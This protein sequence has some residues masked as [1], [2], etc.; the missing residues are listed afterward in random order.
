MPSYAPRTDPFSGAGD[1]NIF[2]APAV[3]HANN[4]TN[5]LHHPPTPTSAHALNLHSCWAEA[6]I[7]IARMTLTIKLDG[8]WSSFQLANN[9]PPLSVTG[10]VIAP[11]ARMAIGAAA[12]DVHLRA[13]RRQYRRSGGAGRVAPRYPPGKVYPGP[14]APPRAGVH[15]PKTSLARGRAGRGAVH[16]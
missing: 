11:S 3:Q 16:R 9:T 12:G 1:G 13:A 6:R 8:N 4:T 5:P 10:S 7:K 2:A 14:R 15:L